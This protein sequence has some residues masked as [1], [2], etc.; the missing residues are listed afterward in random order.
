MMSST[1]HPE[2]RGLLNKIPESYA[3]DPVSGV[4]TAVP[5]PLNLPAREDC[6]GHGLFSTIGDFAR[7]L[8]AVLSGGG[9]ILTKE[10]VDQIFSP[11]LNDTSCLSRWAYGDYKSIIAPAIPKGLKI[12]HGLG[13][14]INM[15]PI[16]G[17]R[18]KGSLQWLGMVNQFWVSLAKYRAIWWEKGTLTCAVD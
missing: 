7:L 2:S 17:R 6:G 12:D 9:S 4:L 11:Q 16:S 14:L 10:S 13:G 8:A 1:F 5:L 18:S 15:E 3:R